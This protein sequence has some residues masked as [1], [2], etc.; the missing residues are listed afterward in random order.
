LRAA[1]EQLGDRLSVLLV[2]NSRSLL[3]VDAAS[4]ARVAYSPRLEPLP[5][6]LKQSLRSRCDTQLWSEQFALVRFPL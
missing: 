2:I 3:W 5:Q 6:W 4:Q 1:H